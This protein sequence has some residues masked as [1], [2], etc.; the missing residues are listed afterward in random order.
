[1]HS[2]VA[3]MVSGGCGGVV[4]G[5][6]AIGIKPDVFNLSAGIKNTLELSAAAFVLNAIL[7][8]AFFL[9][10]SPLPPDDPK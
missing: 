9:K 8:V 6:A 1:M 5:F 3:A 4:N 7:G 2:L 10:Q